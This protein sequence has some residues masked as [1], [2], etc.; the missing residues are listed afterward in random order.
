MQQYLPLY[1]C[2]SMV[3]V[4]TFCAFLQE[5]F[6]AL[7]FWVSALGGA[8]LCKPSYITSFRKLVFI[9]LLLAHKNCVISLLLSK[10]LFIRGLIQSTVYTCSI[11]SLCTVLWEQLALVYQEH[12]ALAPLG[13][14]DL[15][16]SEHLALVSLGHLALV[17]LEYLTPVF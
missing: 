1:A 9:N 3:L 11:W 7:A 17:S 10:A 8:F 16:S 14:L 12:L 5:Q 2:S 4:W 6:S 15:V 13:H